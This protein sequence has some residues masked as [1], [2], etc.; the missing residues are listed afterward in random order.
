MDKDILK[1]TDSEF[2]EEYRS[3][4]IFHRSI[5]CE[6]CL[7]SFDQGNEIIK[8]SIGVEIIYQYVSN[9]EDLAMIFFSLRDIDKYDG[10][11]VKSL[12]EICIRED[13]DK[14]STEALI[15]DID[16]ITG[17][18]F[19][20]ILKEIHLPKFEEIKNDLELTSD[21]K[22]KITQF[23]SQYEKEIRNVLYAIKSSVSNRKFGKDGQGFDFVKIGNKIKHGSMFL[24]NH[25]NSSAV[26]YPLKV[27]VDIK[28]KENIIEGYDLISSKKES[29][30]IVV[31]NIKNIGKV[32]SDL[33]MIFNKYHQKNGYQS[34][35]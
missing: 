8:R 20:N 11:F 17:L 12:Q 22:L 24:L 27:N 4:N 16:R 13:S 1:I 7:K 30:E 5:I 23:E 21:E 18:S 25:N 29:L 10:S 31:E 15:K 35:I 34:G 19:E 6:A 14:Y 28:T 33:L 2:I 26:F 32:T 9:L 3:L